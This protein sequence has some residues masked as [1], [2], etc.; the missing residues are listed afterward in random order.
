MDSFNEG[1]IQELVGPSVLLTE[2]RVLREVDSTNSY[3]KELAGKV[4]PGLVL[5]ADH[6]TQGR[7]RGGKP[8]VARPGDAINCSILLRPSL[9]RHHLYL[10]G[11]ACALS[12]A[13]GLAPFVTVAPVLKWPN[14]VLLGRGKVCG[15]LTETVH[16]RGGGLWLVLGFGTNV[17]D[18]PP[19]DIAPG[20]VCVDEYG[21]RPVTRVEIAARILRILSVMLTALYSGEVESTWNAWRNSLQTIGQKVNV[22]LPMGTLSGTAIDVQRDGALV[23]V[24][25]HGGPREIVYAADVSRVRT[26]E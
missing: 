22:A 15:V 21:I 6:Q 4:A 2:F 20:A 17:H 8:W 7:G 14:D 18:V 3:L 12:V 26:V 1:E 13:R 5:L 19:S 23:V 11:A 25:K 16:P 10:M 9:E 24:P